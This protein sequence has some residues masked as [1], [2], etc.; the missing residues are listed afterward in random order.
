MSDRDA[1]GVIPALLS[2][3]DINHRTLPW[4]AIGPQNPNPY[5]VWLSEMM[6]Q[7]TTVPTVLAYFARFI[8]IWPTIQDL[9][10]ATSEEIL[11]QWQGL[12]YYSRARN[13]H[14]CAQKVM[15][16]F[17]GIFPKTTSEL[18]NLP[19]I[20]PYSAAAIASIAFDQPVLPVDGNI[21]RIFSRLHALEASYENLA[22]EI[23]E[24]SKTFQDFPR[25]GD[26]AQGLMDLGTSVCTP[27]KPLCPQCP[28]STQCKA[29]KEGTVGQFPKR[30]EK[31]PK[32]VKY[33]L[34]HVYTNSTGDIMLR[35]RPHKGLL[36]NMYEVPNTLW[37][38]TAPQGF[39]TPQVIHIFTHIKLMV[40]VRL[41]T[42]QALLENCFW[43]PRKDL[44]TYPIPT[45]MKKVIRHTLGPI[46]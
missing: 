18:I 28:L 12:G 39:H 40:D 7:Q 14:L 35:Q 41:E 21:K 22:K 26:F 43:C 37:D 6:L 34:A 9:A 31:K 23:T 24:I 42:R 46:I 10:K 44:H 32:L 36:A 45:L 17:G 20:G 16:D 38:L 13:L 33:T 25:P 2:W 29:F 15:T 4:R 8:H 30:P 27:T 19:G 3:Y 11:T 5:H 1:Q